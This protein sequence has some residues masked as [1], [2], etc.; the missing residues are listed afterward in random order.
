MEDH[1]IEKAMAIIEDLR[2]KEIILNAE[3]IF[4][5]RAVLAWLNAPR[6]PANPEHTVPVP[7]TREEVAASDCIAKAVKIIPFLVL[8]TTR[9]GM[10]SSYGLK[11][12]IEKVITTQKEGSYMANGQ[13]ILAMLLLGYTIVFSREGSWNCTFHCKYA[14]ND[15]YESSNKTSI[16][17][18]RKI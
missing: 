1:L 6:H 12:Y 18:W 15:Y 17:T 3:G 10:V 8:K 7:F 5:K 11:H 2:C 16:E 4:D 9:K 14:R 13:A